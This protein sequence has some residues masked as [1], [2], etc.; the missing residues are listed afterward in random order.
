MANYRFYNGGDK[1]N[2]RIPFDNPNNDIKVDNI[3]SYYHLQAPAQ[4]YFEVPDSIATGRNRSFSNFDL[5]VMS[6]WGQL[7]VVRVDRDIDPAMSATP[8][9]P[10]DREAKILGDR[11]HEEYLTKLVQDYVNRVE[12][13]KAQGKLILPAQGYTK[14][15][16]KKLGIA[17]PALTVKN[18]V[19]KQK[20]GSDEDK[21]KISLLEAQIKQMQDQQTAF[22]AGIMGKLT[23]PPAEAPAGKAASAK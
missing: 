21:L 19:E 16:L 14:H 12:E 1:I 7:G 6:K 17:D 10:D 3:V 20:S 22:F 2:D 9:A 13:A 4:G 5:T 8:V 11:I 18:M 15:A 23:P